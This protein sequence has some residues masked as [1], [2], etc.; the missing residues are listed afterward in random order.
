[1]NSSYLIFFF[2]SPETQKSFLWPWFVVSHKFAVLLGFET[3]SPTVMDKG[4]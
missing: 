2:F 1:M 3:G 4:S